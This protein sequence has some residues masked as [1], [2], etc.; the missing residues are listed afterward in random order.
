MTSGTGEPPSTKVAT[1]RAQF[2]AIGGTFAPVEGHPREYVVTFRGESVLAIHDDDN[3]EWSI[4]LSD[5]GDYWLNLIS[6]RKD[7][8]FRH[9]SAQKLADL[10]KTRGFGV[11]VRGT[12]L[13]RIYCIDHPRLGYVAELV[14]PRGSQVLVDVRFGDEAQLRFFE[15][16]HELLTVGWRPQ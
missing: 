5:V 12:L 15:A 2:I 3:G 16:I 10:A 6:F 9:V 1:L 13:Q 8:G 4:G 14:A 11:E 7:L